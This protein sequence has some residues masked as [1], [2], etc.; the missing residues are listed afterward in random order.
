MNLQQKHTNEEW[1]KYVDLTVGNLVCVGGFDF[2]FA[3]GDDFVRG[4]WST[5]RFIKSMDTLIFSI[6]FLEKKILVRE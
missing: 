3:V 4:F 5:M 2:K 1:Q 6:C